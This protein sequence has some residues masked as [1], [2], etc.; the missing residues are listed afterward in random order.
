VHDLSDDYAP[1]A[2]PPSFAPS[3]PTT[4]AAVRVLTFAE[5]FANASHPIALDSYQRPYVWGTEKTAQLLQ[6][7]VEFSSN[8]ADAL[9]YY[10]GTIL[11]H[12]NQAKASFLVIDGQQRLTTLCLLHRHLLQSLPP[13][14][15]LNFSNSESWKNIRSNA[16]R[17][18]AVHA[19]LPPPIIFDRIRFTVITVD[20]ED[21]A[22]TFFDS[23]NNR[24]MPL[25][26]TDLLKA[27]HLR[28]IDGQ[29]SSSLALQMSCA[30]RWEGLQNLPPLL[31]QGAD[32]APSLFQC[33]L[34][35]GRRWTGRH[36]DARAS[37][38]DLIHEFQDRSIRSPSLD[39]VPLYSSRGNRR[40]TAITLV[41]RDGYR[42]KGEDIP[43]SSD[44]AELPFAIRQP[45][46][47]GVGF[48]LY[49]EKYAALSRQLLNP[50]HEDPEVR[51]F[52]RFH[53]AVIEPVS[54]YLRELFLLA[55]LLFVDQFGY[56]QLLRF[57]LWLDHALG[58][59]RIEKAYIFEAAP[60]N[61]LRNGS[62]N[63]L[64]VIVGSFRPEEVIAYLQALPEPVV[65]YA[66]RD[67]SG[68]GVQGRYKQSVLA[69]YGRLDSLKG[70][71][72]WIEPKLQ[73][74][75]CA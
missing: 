22:F 69:Y 62:Q 51:A 13:R 11:L 65:I 10:M 71:D 36:L 48:F 32:F 23:Q 60:L 20:T 72:T 4:G 28:A 75:N 31:G 16:E 57:A 29:D 43:L 30:A 2:I 38:D 67:V 17:M 52:Q 25:A 34:W 24:G 33:F 63:L 15:G 68:N 41:P 9:D 35:R 42:L 40:A 66:T 14:C 19:K 54:I 74:E 49:C 3:P 46:S 1:P 26:A 73:S 53:Q 47:A 21:L 5:L 45:L 61:F 27:Y 59:I 64:D 37:H 18:A 56:R 50:Q 39:T 7:L 55:C 8:G 44:P 6:D 58:A 70:R 12:W